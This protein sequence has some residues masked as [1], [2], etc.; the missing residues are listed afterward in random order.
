MESLGFLKH[1]A[2]HKYQKSVKLSQPVQSSVENDPLDVKTRILTFWWTMIFD[3]FPPKFTSNF[4]ITDEYGAMVIGSCFSGI[5]SV[6]FSYLSIAFGAEP[7]LTGLNF[8]FVMV[9]GTDD[10]FIKQIVINN[11]SL[12]ESLSFSIIVKRRFIN[13][14]R[15]A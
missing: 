12:I 1:F 5:R 7:R 2:F 6:P 13:C 8:V 15:Y 11:N 3:E 4:W 9:M 10:S 14:L